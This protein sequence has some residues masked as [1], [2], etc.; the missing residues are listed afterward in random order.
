MLSID[1]AEQVIYVKI[2]IGDDEQSGD[3]DSV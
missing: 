2:V 3:V 1:I